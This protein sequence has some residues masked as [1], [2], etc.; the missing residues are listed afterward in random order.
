MESECIRIKM[1]TSKITINNL[2]LKLILCDLSQNSFHKF[3]VTVFTIQYN[4]STRL[5]QGCSKGNSLLTSYQWIVWYLQSEAML[6]S[7]C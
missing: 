1:Y 6:V 7:A 3:T 2:A 5:G 4:I